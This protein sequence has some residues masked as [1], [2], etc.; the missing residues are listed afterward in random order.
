MVG[1]DEGEFSP[2]YWSMLWSWLENG[3]IQCVAGYLRA[4]D[5]SGFNAK[6]PPPKTRAF[7]EI[8][9]SGRAPE[10]AEMADA[11]DG[12]DRPDVIT[13]DMIRLT[14]SAE[15]A[16]WL[17]DRRN[18]RQVPYRI[19]ECGYVQVLNDCAKDRLWK[20]KGRRQAVYAKRELSERDQIAAAMKLTR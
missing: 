9:N 6:A 14:S 1:G 18:R 20:I 7:W 10:T 17:H 4:P 3:G 19:E 16:E 15:F 12:L 8:V 11:L 13:L 5:L 2:E